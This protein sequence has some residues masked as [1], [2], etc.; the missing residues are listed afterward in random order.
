[1][2]KVKWLDF[3]VSME[4]TTTVSFLIARSSNMERD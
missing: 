4:N 1:M 2:S 3:T